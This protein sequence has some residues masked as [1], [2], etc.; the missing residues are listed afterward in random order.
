MTLFFGL[1]QEIILQ[2]SDIGYRVF[3]LGSETVLLFDQSCC[4]PISDKEEQNKTNHIHESDGEQEVANCRPLPESESSPHKEK[5]NNITINSVERKT[6][7]IARKQ[8][9]PNNTPHQSKENRTITAEKNDRTITA[10][11]NGRPIT[12]EKNDRTINPI[13]KTTQ[14]QNYNSNKP[15]E[16]TPTSQKSPGWDSSFNRMVA[17]NGYTGLVN[18]ISSIHSPDTSSNILT[19]S[20]NTLYA[21]PSM[22]SG[23]YNSNKDSGLPLFDESEDEEN[24]SRLLDN[25]YSTKIK[26][27]EDRVAKVEAYC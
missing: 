11:K 23:H 3:T 27:L 9:I 12:A 1:Y 18:S 17:T 4:F 15:C 13:N 24:V 19:E 7:P 26:K 21:L 16:S 14:N 22:P 20:M 5:Q 2:F 8:I 10:E 25:H 6:T